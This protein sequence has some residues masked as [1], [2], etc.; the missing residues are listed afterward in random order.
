M[1]STDSVSGAEEA[2]LNRNRSFKS[3]QLVRSQAIR[4]STSPPRTASPSTE[5]VIENIKVDNDKTII[6]KMT[7]DEKITVTEKI[8]VNDNGDIITDTSSQSG[9][10]CIDANSFSDSK[11]NYSDEFKKQTVEI[12]I[13]PGAWDEQTEQRQRTKRWLG[14]RHHSDSSRDLLS[15]NPRVACV[16]GACAACLHCRGR[17][18]KNL[19]PTKQDSGIVCSD[20]CPDCS[21]S[22]QSGTHNDDGRK[23]DT[24]D[25]DQTIY[26]RCPDRKDVKPKAISLSRNDSEDKSEP[27]GAELVTFIKQTLNKNA[28]DRM[29]L[30][31][32]EKEL[33]ALVNDNGRC[34]VR[35]PV[36]TS[37]GRM[38]VHRCAALFQ[39]SHH[40]DQN[41][42]SSVMV[43]K[44]GTS[45]GRIPCTGFRQWCT[46]TFPPSPQHNHQ[47]TLA[48]SI[49]KRDTHSLDEPGNCSL[50]NA[51][52]K[53]LEQREREYERV[54]RRIFS[55]DNCTQDESHCL[56]A[57]SGPVKL[58]TAEP[59]RNKLLKVQSLESSSGPQQS[60]RGRGAVAKSH[61][62]GGYGGTQVQY[63]PTTRVLSKQGDVASSSWRLSPSSSGYKTL[64]LSTDSVCSPTG[65]VSPEPLCPGGGG[66]GGAGGVVWCVT[67]LCSVPSGAMLIH[68]QT[69]RPLTNPD[70]SIYHFDPANPPTL[71]DSSYTQLDQEKIDA[72][73]KRKGRLEKQHSFIDNDCECQLS[74]ECSRKCC[75]ECRR[76]DVCQ[77]KNNLDKANQQPEQKSKP[78]TPIKT[79][80]ENQTNHNSN[81]TELN[82]KNYEIP[83]PETQRQYDT[84]HYENSDRTFENNQRC[85]TS[86]HR[87]YD[88]QQPNQ[89][90][91]EHPPPN[92]RPNEAANQRQVVNKLTNQESQEMYAT[93]YPT[94]VRNDEVTSPQMN[95]YQQE[96]NLQIMAQAKLTPVSMPDPNIRP[97]SLTNV[98]YP[99][100]APGYPYVNQCRMETQLQPMYQTMMAEEQKQV[101]P[102]PHPVDNTFRIDPSYP[103]AGVDYSQCGACVDPNVVHQRSY[104]V[105]Y[106]PVEVPV[107]P[108]YPVGNMVLPQ[109]P[110]QHYPYGDPLQWTNSMLPMAPKLLVP[111]LY[112]A[113]YPCPQYNVYPQ[114]VPPAPPAPPACPPQWAACARRYKP[115]S[116][117]S[118]AAEEKSLSRQ[119]SNEIAAKI[120]QIKEQMSQLNTRDRREEW[121]TG[122]GILGSCPAANNERRT[123][124][125]ETQ[126]SSAAR[127]IVNSIRNMQAKSLQPERRAERERRR[128][129]DRV[130]PTL[131]RQMSPGTWCRRSPAAVHPVLNHPRRPH[132]DNRNQ[133]R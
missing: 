55:T 68:P 54:R 65:G 84:K 1:E 15:N 87:Q 79:R 4:E 126:L 127:A 33:R 110:M 57:N 18:R 66:G 107:L 63:P 21:D 94:G 83:K 91:F 64:S 67:D 72:N 73:E 23:S 133:R 131:L 6:D 117:N 76:H 59:G 106:G 97:M 24:L 56:W 88:H 41:N 40:L 45:G 52:S 9:D 10:T 11:S 12:Q 103:Y 34:I 111:D 2:L 28:R 29:T 102:S 132:P 101:A 89:R 125:D 46:A 13:T 129:D 42:K 39:L 99:T 32:I 122:S 93:Q 70:G 22:E 62:F 128:P 44:S 119:N 118:H 98:M 69:G 20:D 8:T 100:I 16:C 5:I 104:N 25:D 49:L 75:C 92:Q 50:A 17:R 3:K 121:R 26:C 82:H 7:V 71:Y 109:S 38:L 112:P 19:C 31:K 90:Q 35:F 36:M 77:Q 53:S 105:S 114:L 115:L 51:R 78:T 47:D 30:L 80:Y 116:D 120:Q 113:M 74:E 37:Y 96:V 124:N 130:Y 48:K 81:Q 43:S 108:T 86:N 95:Q 85:E 14:H 58:L 123:P 60:W 27:S 61:S